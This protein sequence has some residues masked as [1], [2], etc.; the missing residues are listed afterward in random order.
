MKIGDKEMAFP[1]VVNYPILFYPAQGT[2]T[3]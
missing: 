3:F 1:L 2:L